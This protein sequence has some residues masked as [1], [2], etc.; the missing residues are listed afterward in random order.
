MS[1]VGRC[2]GFLLPAASMV[3]FTS[4][5]PIATR[6][7]ERIRS[8]DGVVE[9]LVVQ[10]NGGATTSLVE[11]V[12]VVPTGANVPAGN[13]DVFRADRVSEL[14]VHWMGVRHLVIAYQHARIFDYTNF[15]EARAVDDFRY[16][17][18]IG[19]RSTD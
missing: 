13:L 18:H 14:V 3:V 8:P 4:C 19:L 10:R 9:A 2:T 12:F 16:I 5:S 15:W 17:V 11:E 1:L 7:M 6:L